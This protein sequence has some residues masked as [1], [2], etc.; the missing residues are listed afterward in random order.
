MENFL[1]EQ[2][3]ITVL[4]GLILTVFGYRSGEWM[5]NFLI[6]RDRSV[7]SFICLTLLALFASVAVL[8]IWKTVLFC[9]VCITT[10][11]FSLGVLTGSTER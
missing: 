6:N 11:S 4:L 3:A 8:F 1:F 9:L 7:F 2:A 10:S 5:L